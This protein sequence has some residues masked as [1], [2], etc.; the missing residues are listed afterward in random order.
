MNTIMQPSTTY[1]PAPSLVKMV[2]KVS[3]FTIAGTLM[4]LVLFVIMSKL[5]ETEAS[6]IEPAPAITVNVNGIK[7]EEPT[8]EK[9]NPLP[10]PPKAKPMPPQVKQD[11]AQNDNLELGPPGIDVE[12]PS[13]GLTKIGLG[14]PKN[15]SAT[16]IFR[17]E[18]QYP[19]KAAT[20]GIEGWVSLSFSI[21]KLGRVI[22]VKVM[23]A[24]PKRY[25]EHAARK[26]LRK[27]K[28]QPK[29]VNGKPVVQSGQSILLEFGMTQS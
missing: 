13:I 18:P 12:I 19:I 27:W 7:D 22:D 15:K 23:D 10:E 9:V 24:K 6:F 14:G 25:F 20:N 26:A 21:D 2:L 1:L 3:G 29:L 28:Y 4:A 5:A 8:K 16:P 11:L 17:V